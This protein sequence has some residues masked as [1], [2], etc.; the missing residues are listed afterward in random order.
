MLLAGASSQVV[1][2][3]LQSAAATASLKWLILASF[4]IRRAMVSVFQVQL[5]HV[6]AVTESPVI[7]S[8]RTAD[9]ASTFQRRGRLR[10]SG[11][12]KVLM[13]TRMRSIPTPPEK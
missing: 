3:E 11:M 13:P 9:T 1:V 7:S 10:P 2:Q 12:Q 5:L 4:T 8:A 6:L